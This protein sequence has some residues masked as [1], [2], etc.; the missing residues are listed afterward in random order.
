MGLAA[1]VA[2]PDPARAL[3]LAL[4]MW[5]LLTLAVADLRWFR[6]PDPL[7]LVAAAAGLALALAG[8]GS[9]WP[10]LTA[11]AQDAMIGAAAG[12]GSFW[13]IRVT[14]RWWAG[15]DG[16]GLGDVKLM[17]ALGLGLGVERLPLVVLFAALVAL[18]LSVLRAWRK[19]R[20][21]N[22]LGRVPFGAALALSAAV[23]AI[24]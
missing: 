8:D 18:A 6:L 1:A 23:V 20:P 22:R 13:L 12:G 5:A 16:M 3:L 14:Y 7:V 19:R 2:A 17:A 11:R 4:W 15:R 10:D 9:G 24:L 21:L